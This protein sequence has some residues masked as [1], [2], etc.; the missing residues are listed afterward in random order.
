MLPGRG[1]QGGGG[2]R[3]TPFPPANFTQVKQKTPM[4]LDKFAE[5]GREAVMRIY[6]VGSE[7]GH[8]PPI[9]SDPNA[10]NRVDYVG[11][12][13]LPP[14]VTNWGPAHTH[15][16]DSRI[17]ESYDPQTG[18]G[19]IETDIETTIRWWKT[20]ADADGEGMTGGTMWI[21]LNQGEVI[22]IDPNTR[23][24]FQVRP[25]TKPGA[26]AVFRDPLPIPDELFR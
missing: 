26:K 3:P 5:R 1:G 7:V 11:R 10:P 22:V 21:R 23:K 15:P 18:R 14:G 2:G 24:I 19:S 12:S 25:P 8:T 4:I 9:Y 20:P 13:A 16:T 6:S 17:Q